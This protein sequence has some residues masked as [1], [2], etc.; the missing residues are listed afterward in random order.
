MARQRLGYRQM[1]VDGRYVVVGGGNGLVGP[2]YGQIAGAEPV[3]SLRTGN[4]V[5]KMAIDIDHL[6]AAI[7]RAH[8]MGVPYFVE[9]RFA[10]NGFSIKQR[11]QRLL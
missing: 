4:L 11:L 7:H 8:G 3:K 2:E 5:N 10:H 9:K 1:L 6:L